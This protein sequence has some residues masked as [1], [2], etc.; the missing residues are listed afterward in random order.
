MWK[1]KRKKNYI[2]MSF[3]LKKKKKNTSWCDI[4]SKKVKNVLNWFFFWRSENKKRWGKNEF[5]TGLIL[6]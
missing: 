6:Q 4:K 1:S 2:V 3:Y 5:Q